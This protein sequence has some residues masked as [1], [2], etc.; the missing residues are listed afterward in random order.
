LVGTR[1]Q[2]K[3]DTNNETATA[4]FTHRYTKALHVAVGKI[5]AYN[6][7]K[8]FGMSGLKRLNDHAHC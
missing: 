5:K 2:Y 1:R 7:Q 3:K 8:L 6:K 4:A